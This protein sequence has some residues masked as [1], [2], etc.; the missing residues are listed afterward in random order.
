MYNYLKLLKSLTYCFQ[1]TYTLNL[2]FL[3][4][5]STSILGNKHEHE[6]VDNS[7]FVFLIE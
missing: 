1:Y 2:Q 5:Y 3:H 7:I 6:F 4:R